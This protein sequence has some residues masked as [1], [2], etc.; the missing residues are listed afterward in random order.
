MPIYFYS[1]LALNKNISLVY[2]PKYVRW[3]I[4]CL[5]IGDFKPKNLNEFTRIHSTTALSNSESILNEICMETIIF[6]YW[7]KSHIC[8]KIACYGINLDGNHSWCHKA[9]NPQNQLMNWWKIQ[10]LNYI[11][12]YLIDKLLC[13]IPV[14]S[15]RKLTNW[16]ANKIQ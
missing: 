14:E 3:K 16:R 8:I 2:V 5:L 4:G 10:H 6:E 9:R 1:F 11:V 12:E 15:T 7:M 13:E